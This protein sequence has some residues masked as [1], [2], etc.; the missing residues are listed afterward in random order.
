METL[1]DSQQQM[2]GTLYTEH[3]GWLQGWLRKRLGCVFEAAD[4]AHDTFVRIA[5]Q[6]ELENLRE[7]RAYLTTVAHGLM[8]NQLRRRKLE[9]AYLAALAQAPAHEIPSPEAQ[10]MLLETLLEI[11]ALLDGLPGKVRMAFLMVQL[12]GASHA[13]IARRLDVSVSSVRKY[14]MRALAHCLSVDT[15]SA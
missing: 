15:P 7:P 6:H 1:P 5:V 2:L 3:H 10:A 14:I 9:Q 4:L 13:D 12:E 11:D 8:V